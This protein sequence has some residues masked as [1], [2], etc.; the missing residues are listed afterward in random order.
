MA[1]CPSAGQSAD[2]CLVKRTNA[3]GFENTARYLPEGALI[4]DTTVSLDVAGALLGPSVAGTT[5]T[6][7]F[8]SSG[9]AE[10]MGGVVAGAPSPTLTVSSD[11]GSPSQV[12]TIN[13]ATSR[14]KVD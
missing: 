2:Y 13:T 8:N 9:S 1:D 11:D 6:V 3:G 4:S 10:A 12:I 5:R 7:K 14:V